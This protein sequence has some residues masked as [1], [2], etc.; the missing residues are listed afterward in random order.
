MNLNI[1]LKFQESTQIAVLIVTLIFC[2]TVIITASAYD[3][4]NSKIA[5]KKQAIIFYATIA[6]TLII[7]IGSGVIAYITLIKT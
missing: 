3:L 4:T 5:H 2:A 1:P 7:T 6:L